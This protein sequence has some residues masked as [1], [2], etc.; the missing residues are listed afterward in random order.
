[1]NEDAIEARLNMLVYN[2][3]QVTLAM[4]QIQTQLKELMELRAQGDQTELNFD[5]Y[6]NVS[7][8]TDEN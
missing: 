6:D 7:P 4:K 3:N 1:M 2:V 5:D 8:I